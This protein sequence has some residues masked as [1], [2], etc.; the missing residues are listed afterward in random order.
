MTLDPSFFVGDIPVFGDVILA[1][2]AGY[3]DV[4]HRS[5]CRSFGS[6]MNYTEFVATEDVINKTKTARSLLDFTKDERPMV[7]QLFGNEPRKFLDAALRVE[8]LDLTGTSRFDGQS[9]QKTQDPTFA[10]ARH[11]SRDNRTRHLA[12]ADVRVTIPRSGA[13]TP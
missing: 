13:G 9:Y 2:M 4:P 7:V 1:P 8:E 10:A 12:A 3:A 5:L 6:A 11:C